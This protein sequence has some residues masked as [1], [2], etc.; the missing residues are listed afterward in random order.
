[1]REKRSAGKGGG[2]LCEREEESGEGGGILCEREEG[3]GFN[4]LSVAKGHPC[5]A[6]REGVLLETPRPNALKPASKRKVAAKTSFDFTFIV[7]YCS[8]S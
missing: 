7:S 1:M 6:E 3:G 2:N 4:V 8:V 5:D